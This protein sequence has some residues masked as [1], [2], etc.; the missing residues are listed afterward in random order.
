VGAPASS[1]EDRQ[2]SILIG[3]SG[4]RRV[5]RGEIHGGGRWQSPI[6]RGGCETLPAHVD[7]PSEHRSYPVASLAISTCSPDEIDS[8]EE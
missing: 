7:V 4:G 3:S 8:G 1:G 2:R 5:A 6:R